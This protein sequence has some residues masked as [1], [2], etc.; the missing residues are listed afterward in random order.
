MNYFG[1]KNDVRRP[2]SCYW[3][4]V[5]LL[6]SVFA[7]EECIAQKNI[8]MNS[9][10]ADSVMSV[11]GE[12][13]EV[14]LYCG[15]GEEPATYM[16]LCDYWKEGVN[17]RFEVWVLGYDL[18]TG[19][20]V[21]LPIGPSCIWI[22]KSGSV[23][24]VGNY[25]SLDTETKHFPYEWKVPKY[26]LVSCL[27]YTGEMQPS[28][29][30]KVHAGAQGEDIWNRMEQD[31][32]WSRDMEQKQDIERQRQKEYEK[33][34]KQQTEDFGKEKAETERWQKIINDEK[35]ERLRKELKNF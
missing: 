31:D 21:C 33:K 24:N 28:Y 32:K 12:N 26:S 14:V 10:Q 6:L 25:L 8:Y 35:N 16:V 23:Y 7:A 30:Y 18:H 34:L 19:D 5:V 11:I 1:N 9:N 20:T 2:I 29:H 17:G 15:Y 4:L 13:K 3:G 27:E 22:Q